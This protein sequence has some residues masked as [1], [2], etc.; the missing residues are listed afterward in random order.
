[1]RL[2]KQGIVILTILSTLLS[3]SMAWSEGKLKERIEDFKTSR[4]NNNSALT[5]GD[6]TFS[7]SRPNHNRQ[8]MVHIPKSYNPNQ[9]AP[10]VL[11]LHGG[12]GNM[13]YQATCKYYHLVA[14]SE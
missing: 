13:E 11:S 5:A 1:M 4:Q 10:L 2:K 14:K 7:L 8:Y 3:T 6:Y 9:P 12:G